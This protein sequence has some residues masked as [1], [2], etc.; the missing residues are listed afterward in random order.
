MATEAMEAALAR[1]VA[2]QEIEDCVFRYMRGQ[3]RL[4]ASLQRSAFHDD[5]TVDYGF[6]KGAGVDFVDFAQGLLARWR[7]L[8]GQFTG[9]DPAIQQG[10][11]KMYADQPNW[12]AQRQQQF[13]VKPQIQ[14]FMLKAMQAAGMAPR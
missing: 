7:E 2:R 12:P 14:E 10:L 8:V 5:A 6:Y 13:G 3:D 9:G 1:L 4:D 11:N